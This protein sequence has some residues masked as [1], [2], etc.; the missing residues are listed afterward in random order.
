V[1]G[2]SPTWASHGGAS[3]V[4]VLTGAR[5]VERLSESMAGSVSDE[6]STWC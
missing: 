2:D 4:E 5:P 6:A 3:W 1:V